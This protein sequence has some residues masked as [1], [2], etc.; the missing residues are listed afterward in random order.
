[1]K[2]P[3]ITLLLTALL[4][5]GCAVSMERLDAVENSVEQLLDPAAP[6]AG[7]AQL[8]TREEAQ[9]IALKHAGFTAGQVTYLRTEYEIDDG[10]PQ[11]QVEFHQG[12]WEY[13]YEIQAETGEVLSFEKEE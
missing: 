7:T 12:G 1:M 8:L 11:Y 4:L 6:A 2:Y 5:S 9:D 3:V 13:S 10:V